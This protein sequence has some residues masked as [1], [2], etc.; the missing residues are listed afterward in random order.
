MCIKN[1]SSGVSYQ[2]D[3]CEKQQQDK[4]KIQFVLGF[5]LISNSTQSFFLS[6][7]HLSLRHIYTFSMYF[8]AFN[9]IFPLKTRREAKKHQR[10][11]EENISRA[12]NEF[13]QRFMCLF[14]ICSKKPFSGGNSQMLDLSSAPHTNECDEQMPRNIFIMRN[15]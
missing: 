2:S 15:Y 9:Y 13:S 10:T 8:F 3:Y 6:R 12:D 14:L 5:F 11:Q 1:V 4:A 7:Y